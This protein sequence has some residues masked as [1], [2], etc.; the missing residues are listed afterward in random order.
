MDQPF[1]TKESSKLPVNIEGVPH[2]ANVIKELWERTS[3][4]LDVNELEWFGRA[5]E[6]SQAMAQNLEEVL[7]QMGCIA[8]QNGQCNG[9]LYAEYLQTSETA[10]IL[11]FFVSDAIRGI[12]ALMKI[13]ED[14]NYK[15]YRNELLNPLSTKK[16]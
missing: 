6:I 3:D 8:G 2:L 7:E 10:S 12:R 11:F 4:Q 13:S 1:K 15:R 5:G 14:A 9:K 16:D